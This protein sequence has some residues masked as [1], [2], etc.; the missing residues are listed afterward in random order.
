[1]Y[2]NQIDPILQTYSSSL[3]NFAYV[4]HSSV[5]MDSLYVQVT[6]AY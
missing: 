5:G 1:M 6:S 4:T 3:K 2:A